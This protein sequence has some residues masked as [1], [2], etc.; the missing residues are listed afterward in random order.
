MGMSLI[1]PWNDPGGT[2]CCCEPDR[3]SCGSSALA[4]AIGFNSIVQ[5]TGYYEWRPPREI[6]DSLRAGAPFE[7][8]M[9]VQVIGGPDAISGFQSFSNQA[10][11]SQTGCQIV[12]RDPTAPTSGDTRSLMLL[13][14][15]S[16]LIYPMQLSNLAQIILQDENG[17]WTGTTTSNESPAL[18]FVFNFFEGFTTTVSGRFEMNSF[19]KN[20]GTSASVF[21]YSLP[22]I[23]TQKSG[24]TVTVN[25]SI[26]FAAP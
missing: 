21:G 23:E 10:Q 12:L 17:G 26:D 8:E 24:G 15:A 1:V 25:F 6:Y 2:P 4:N 7:Y 11:L 18:Y 19:F 16:G 9:S 5:N 13:S 20:G 22:M 3:Q 14:G